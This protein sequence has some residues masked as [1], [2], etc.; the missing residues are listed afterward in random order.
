LELP[1][2]FSAMLSSVISRRFTA[3]AGII[4]YCC[5]L[6]IKKTI[7]KS[8]N[9]MKSSIALVLLVLV[10]F[11]CKHKEK[12]IQVVEERPKDIFH[13]DL[14]QTLNSSVMSLFGES[15]NNREKYPDL[16]STS[17][18]EKIV[19][20]KESSVYISYVTEG[21]AI[22]S[23]LGW[24]IYQSSAPGSSSDID[25]QIV[26]PNVSNAILTPGDT[27]LI[28]HFGA[29]TVI[30]FYLIVGGY[31]NNTVNYSKPTFYTNYGWNPGQQRQHV[32]FRE[33][34]CN[35]I[36]MGFEDKA[37]SDDADN[38]YNDIIF[39]ISDNNS[40]KASSAFDQTTMVG[41]Q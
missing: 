13:L 25:K 30:G 18:Q 41:L 37:V 27:R 17:T 29:G 6:H 40:G 34:N 15:H 9:C 5:H 10:M 26:F 38:D 7:V 19:L 12:V 1:Q 39:M 23:T 36:I 28:G 2:R 11:G 35:N 21:A 32:L 8:K 22:P 16:F 20:T 24:Y 14:C 31:N 4:F 33:T 3:V